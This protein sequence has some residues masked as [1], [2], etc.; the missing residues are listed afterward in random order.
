MIIDWSNSFDEFYPILQENKKMHNSK[1]THSLDELYKLQNLFPDKIYDLKYENLVSNTR[2]EVE[3][4]L[5]FCSLEW[6]DKCLD[7]QKN[8]RVIKTISYNQARKPIYNTSVKSF[9]GY[10]NYLSK[11][12]NL[13]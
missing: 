2:K 6:D 11:L 10:E 4:L 13:N 8:K 9:K 1:P 5:K 12:K 3:K 7:H